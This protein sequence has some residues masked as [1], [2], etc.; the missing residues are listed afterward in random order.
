MSDESTAAA[1]GA[2]TGTT[3]TDQTGTAA[4]TATDT[5]DW[6]AEAEKH[7]ADAEKWKAHSR[8][9]ED[10][11]KAER[12]KAAK[13]G[14]T[15]TEK[16]TAEAEQRGRK[17][18]ATDYGKKL[19]AAE[20]RAACASAG[21]DLGDAAELI[22]PTRFVGEDGEVDEA[23]IKAAVKKLAK[24]APAKTAGKSGGEFTG[25]SGAGTPITEAQ[26]AAMTWQEKAK[27]YSDGKLSHLL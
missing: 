16:A 24:F 21:V 10:T 20:F 4:A 18:A 19:A 27:A 14:M 26:L 12:D 5:T 17:A 8:K 1:T 22:D 15:D 7:R 9:N 3:S 2:E 13:A 11:L 6:K 23:A 25:G